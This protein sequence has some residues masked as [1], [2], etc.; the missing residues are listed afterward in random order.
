MT[1]AMGHLFGSELKCLCGVDFGGHEA[2]PRRCSLSSS[3]PKKGTPRPKKLTYISDLALRRMEAGLTIQ[4][5]AD[6]IRS[7]PRQ[8]SRVE[9]GEVG[10]RGRAAPALAAKVVDYIDS[11]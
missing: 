5:V 10:G 11:V 4:A 8:I 1:D 2:K 7:S 9:R 3:D 6:A